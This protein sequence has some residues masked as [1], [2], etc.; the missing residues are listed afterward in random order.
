ME[1]IVSQE[2]MQFLIMKHMDKD[3]VGE[4]EAKRILAVEGFS[5]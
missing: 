1:N 5:L 2:E 4:L 3:N